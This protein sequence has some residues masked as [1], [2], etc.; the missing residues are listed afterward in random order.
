MALL[1]IFINLS[2]Q[3]QQLL[4]SRLEAM[5]KK[6]NLETKIRDAAM[7]LS[8][9]N[10]SHKRVSKQTDEQLESANRRVESAQHELWRVSE[11]SNEVL[12]KLLEHRAGV[13]GFS[14]RNL[15]NKMV[16]PPQTNGVN[17]SGYSTPSR[18]TQM[19]PT[20][21]S[22]T[23]ASTSSKA[24]F[25]G[26]HLFAGH[27]DAVTPKI[28]K[29][30]LSTSDVA[31][32][33][34][35][36]K[37]TKQAMNA[38]TKQQAEMARELSHLR[39]EKEQIET[40][41][42]MEL[43]SAEETIMSLEKELPRLEGLNAE[44]EELK[45]EKKAWERERE[46]LEGR[47]EVLE[48]KSADATQM[49]HLL[50]DAREQSRNEL[51]QGRAQWEA[52][53]VRWDADR[54]H[55]EEDKAE[56]LKVREE[57]DGGV[58]AL[59]MVAA[60]HGIPVM[61][62]RVSLSGIVESVGLHL[63]E[64]ANQLLTPGGGLRDFTET[65]KV[66]AVLQPVWAML[67]SPE[68]RAAKL[69]GGRPAHQYRSGSQGQ[70]PLGPSSSPAMPPSS[71]SDMDVRSLKTLYDS[72]INMP[73]SPNAA[74]FS[75]EA[76]AARVQALIADDRSLVERLLRFAQAH[77][78]LKKN[79]ER[80]QKLATESNNA[81]ETYQ[82]QVRTLEQRNMSM[83]DKQAALYVAFFLCSFRIFYLNSDLQAR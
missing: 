55:W 37:T 49:K 62:G 57:L 56:S 59:R 73:P 12:K 38:A 13:L 25:D 79:A 36:L 70:N 77:D 20:P 41:M 40:T 69:S 10:A 83:S 78:L 76:F 64:V 48:E 63:A 24:R 52:D 65:S 1:H 27:A 22:V 81:L 61:S 44:L 7:S 72:R 45:R 31:A 4:A 47:L 17:G 8:K 82:K 43:Q 39:L 18:S 34:E 67:P 3:E 16:S 30:P 5:T 60:T 35:R 21:S 71:L 19:S 74:A 6:L 53:K 66:N 15:E 33:E 23:S 14:V 80:A 11:R 28:S 68:L 75:I 29:G 32:L 9:V 58:S 54:A 46:T 51:S 2:I 42:G 26:A 50:A